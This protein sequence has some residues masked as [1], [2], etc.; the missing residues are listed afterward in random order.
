MLYIFR[1]NTVLRRSFL[2]LNEIQVGMWVPYCIDSWFW[3]KII[4]SFSLV[5]RLRI[6]SYK[7][8][9]TFLEYVFFSV[10]LRPP[11]AAMKL[12]CYECGHEVSL[13]VNVQLCLNRLLVL[14]FIWIL[15]YMYIMY[16]NINTIFIDGSKKYWNCVHL[17][18]VL[19]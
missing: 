12:N 3:V 17:I 19:I 6:V 11:H 1:Y 16:I 18:D 2:D 13:K 5:E 15:Y 7:S 9:M 4:G 8:S 10:D 14:Y